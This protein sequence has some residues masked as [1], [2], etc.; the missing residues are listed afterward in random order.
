MAQ[1]INICCQPMQNALNRG[2]D[3]DGYDEL[4]RTSL[5]GK[6]ITAGTDLPPI[7]YCPWCK[8]DVLYGIK[9]RSNEIKEFDKQS[10]ELRDLAEGFLT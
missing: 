8:K 4:F 3:C 10:N 1:L 7:K 2:T 5:N 6:E 9:M